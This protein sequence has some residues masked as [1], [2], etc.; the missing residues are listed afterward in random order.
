MHRK[1]LVSAAVALMPFVCVALSLTCASAQSISPEEARAIAR[2][3]YTYGYPLVQNYG[4]IYSY[5]VDSS[6]PQFKAP[7]NQLRNSPTPANKPLSASDTHSVQLGADLR[8]EPLVLTM[9]ALDTHQY[10][11]V[12][13]LA[14]F[15]F[16]L[17]YTGGR[18]TGNDGGSFLLAGPGW[19]GAKP[20]GIKD[21]IRCPTEF[22]FVLYRRQLLGAAEGERR[23]KNEVELNVQLLHEFLGTPAPP[24]APKVDFMKPFVANQEPNALQF[25]DLL[26]FLLR[27]CPDNPSQE[28]S[29]VQFAKLG[30]GPDANF[31]FNSGNLSSAMRQALTEGAADARRSYKYDAM[32]PGEA[33]TDVSG[34][35][36]F[37]GNKEF[38]TSGGELDESNPTTEFIVS[39]VSIVR[40]ANRGCDQADYYAL[41]CFGWEQIR[42][43][44]ASRP[45]ID[46]ELPFNFLGAHPF[47]PYWINGP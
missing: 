28:D 30:I 44:N 39:L 21:V 36:E 8:A 10:Y 18:S 26:N 14:L 38:G 24:A 20:N 15:A 4:V 7:W 1:Y 22:A 35:G 9:P 34:A 27:F 33:A 13:E 17:A 11:A 45:L 47:N 41:T 2:E 37:W 3:A 6:S 31:S 12:Q 46:F 32:T 23:E 42:S 5:F 19:K 43:V 29:M 25:F 40:S 16:D